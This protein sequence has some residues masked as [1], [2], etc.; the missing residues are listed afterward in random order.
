MC[1]IIVEAAST[2]VF[3]RS[4]DYIEGPFFDLYGTIQQYLYIHYNSRN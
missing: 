2:T 4:K 3:G 1:P